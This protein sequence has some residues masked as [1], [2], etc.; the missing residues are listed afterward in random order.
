M[1]DPQKFYEIASSCTPV[2]DKVSG[3]SY[4]GAYKDPVA[5]HRYQLMYG[6]FLLP[7]VRRQRMLKKPI[8]FLEIGLGCDV[9]YGMFM[10]TLWSLCFLQ[11]FGYRSWGE[12][13]NMAENI[14]LK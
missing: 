14:W 13:S 9:D 1:T 5:N 12:H 2:S 11:F 8:K 7:Y 3:A 4:T 6:T 10:L